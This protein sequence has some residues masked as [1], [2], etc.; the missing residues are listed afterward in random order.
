MTP[1]L[2]WIKAHLLIV[3]MCAISVIVLPVVI[4]ASS[5]WNAKIAKQ[6]AD[7]VNAQNTKIRNASSTT[8]TVKPLVPGAPAIEDNMTV[9]EKMLEEY[10]VVREQIKQDAT[11]LEQWVVAVNRAG[12]EQQ[13]VPGLLPEPS[14]AEINEL[15]FRIHGAFLRAHEELLRQVGAGMPPDPE[16]VQEQLVEYERNYRR[17]QFNVDSQTMLSDSEQKKLT[18]AMTARRLAIYAQAAQEYSVFADISVFNLEAWQS[19]NPPDKFRWYEWQHT[20]WVDLDLMQAVAKANRVDDLPTTIAGRPSSVIKR[21][22]TIKPQSLFSGATEGNVRPGGADPGQPMGMGPEGMGM[23]P[24][25]TA[26]GPEGGAMISK[27]GRFE[28]GD[29][30]APPSAASSAAPAADPGSYA[31]ANQPFPPDFTKSI[32]GRPAKTGLYDKRTVNVTLIVDS[33]R[34][35]DVFKAFHSTNFM[36]VVG[37]KTSP[38]DVTRDLA[39][40]FYYGPD[41]VIEVELEI[42]TLWLRDW[43]VDLMPPPVRTFYGIVEPAP[44]G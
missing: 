1:V 34:L 21:I 44:E 42:E 4:F 28:A 36:S 17:S 30:A 39:Q 10:R 9:N 43:T 8:V 3:I 18:E 2:N 29:G 37:F 41:P 33:S 13:L 11:E 14:R 16:S 24:E 31:D 38:L 6:I 15:P 23:G 12:K 35:Q 32:S 27:F 22:V 20:Y 5:S 19:Q 25:G 26:M 40:G 7:R